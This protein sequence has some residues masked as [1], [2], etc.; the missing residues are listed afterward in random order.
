MASDAAASGSAGS[1]TAA[2]TLNVTTTNALT[3]AVGLQGNGASILATGGGAI[4]SAGDAIAFLGG[5]GQTATFDNFTIGNQTGDLV[6]ADPSVATVN[7]N[8][9]TADAGTNDLIDATAG[10]VV[11]LNANASTLIG[12]IQT[13]AGSMTTV[14]LT[15]GSTW[16]MTGSSVVSNLAVANSVVVFAPP[17]AGGGFKTLTVGN[18]LGS[19]ANLSMNAVLGGAG[20]PSDQII[21]NGGKAT[22]ST[23]ITINNV[24]GLG[25]Q[26]IG[27]GIPLVVAVNGGTIASN[28]FALANTPVVGGYKYTLEESDQDWFL[29]SS[30]TSTAA[31][32]ANSITNVAKAQQQQ[33]ITGSVLSSILLGATEQIN[34]SNCGS[35]FGSIGSYALGA[36]GRWSL[37]DPLT[38]M[39]GFSYDEYTAS[40]I[41]VTNAPTFTGSLV[42]D[43][44][45]FG[46]SR[47]F[48]EIGGGAAPYE[49]VHYN[50]FYP[51]GDTLSLGQG[52]GTDRSLGA[53]G[54]VGW[55]D[56]VTPIDEA[57][58]YTDISRNWLIAGGYT[59]AANGNNPFPATV[60][61]GLDTLNV[62]RVGGQYTHLFGGR[63]EVNASA[64]VAYGFGAGIGPQWNVYDFGPVAPYPI[65]NSAWC[66]W[67][68]RVGYRVAN[69]MV[70][71]AFL[72]GTMGGEIGTTFHGGIGLRYLF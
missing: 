9:T 36:H 5:T 65:A 48:F 72:L 42:Y 6:F 4:A 41:T 30:P 24:G 35:A 37:S 28:A 15:N 71:D 45:N 50:R 56:R 49:Q 1:I 2:G 23:L 67:G 61:T 68:A 3:A 18:Y 11:T 31:E 29:V 59:E 47:P 55:V 69:R 12:A 16:T 19:G 26:T 21:I 43:P 13:G 25:G 17:S 44:V 66:E 60:Q 34:C 7:F 8:N 38:L 52:T 54:R 64:A 46:R 40:G 27:P 32:I 39:G 10:S 57:A 33:I 14:N 20:S 22:G 53:F 70:I 62:W 63:F 51:S 58:V